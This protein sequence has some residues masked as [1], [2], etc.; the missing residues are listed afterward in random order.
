M[1]SRQR[2]QRDQGGTPLTPSPRAE[3]TL[4]HMQAAV[5]DQGSY[6]AAP[7]GGFG[8][9]GRPGGRAAADGAPVPERDSERGVRRA[10]PPSSPQQGFRL[11]FKGQG[12]RKGG[13]EPLGPVPA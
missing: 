7:T 8:G 13:S 10:G 3:G 12:C 2:E 9:E 6:S 11:L 1:P 5:G 4:G